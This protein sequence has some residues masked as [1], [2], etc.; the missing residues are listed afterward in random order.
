[1]VVYRGKDQYQNSNDSYD[2]HGE[3]GNIGFFF[4]AFAKAKGTSSGFQTIR[5]GI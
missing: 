2:T 5:P 1:M 3:C 4:T